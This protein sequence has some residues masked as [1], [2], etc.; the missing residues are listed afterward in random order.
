MSGQL[1]VAPLLR[2]S[3]SAP[4]AANASSS[5]SIPSVLLAYTV[6]PAFTRG[7]CAVAAVRRGVS[8]VARR[9]LG[10]RCLVAVWGLRVKVEQP[11]LGWGREVSWGLAGAKDEFERLQPSVWGE[12]DDLHGGFALA[13]VGF[14]REQGAP[15]EACWPRVGGIN[16]EVHGGAPAV[17][18]SSDE[19]MLRLGG[20]SGGREGL[21]GR[22]R[23]YGA[24][25]GL[26]SLASCERRTRRCV[27]SWQ[28]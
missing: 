25:R 22:G 14:H 8:G 24:W 20:H 7:C 17:A 6:T 27:S 4:L 10:F 16:G 3:R 11:E 21:V 18:A 13:C 2:R 1:G 15:L 12:E 19:E 9:L 23:S 28:R 5:S 26:M